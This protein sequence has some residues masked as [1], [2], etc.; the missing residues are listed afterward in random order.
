[1][2]QAREVHEPAWEIVNCP[3]LDI[4]A[5]NSTI[6]ILLTFISPLHCNNIL[7]ISYVISRFIDDCATFTIRALGNLI[8]RN[9]SVVNDDHDR[10]GAAARC[11]S[12]QSLP[13][14]RAGQSQRGR[15]PW[16][17]SSNRAHKE[18]DSD[19]IPDWSLEAIYDRLEQNAPRIAIIGV[20]P[21]TRPIFHGTPGPEPAA[22]LSIW[23]HGG[24]PFW[25]SVPGSAT[26][27][28]RGN[29][30]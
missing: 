14:R 6:E 22:A 7:L 20:R 11:E 23:K 4:R 21:I 9:R 29:M 10:A 3:L 16:P 15:S 25:F 1:M 5:A 17:A 2:S 26:A 30:A 8:R 28:P 18:A 19:A 12:D 24:V 27:P 13:R